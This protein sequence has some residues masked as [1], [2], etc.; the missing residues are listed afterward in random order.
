[1]T[2]N[3][4]INEENALMEHL[5]K[6]KTS[7]HDE[8]SKERRNLKQ[9]EMDLSRLG[10]EEKESLKQRKKIREE[11]HVLMTEAPKMLLTKRRNQVEY[12]NEKINE[13]KKLVEERIQ[14]V[15]KENEEMISYVKSLPRVTKDK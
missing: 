7:L 5:S 12:L 14:L 13:Y 3:K 9:L 11:G 6:L 8:K 2:Q 15:E 4:I 10:E 1:M